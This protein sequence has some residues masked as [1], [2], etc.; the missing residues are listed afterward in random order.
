M[1]KNKWPEHASNKLQAA[2]NEWNNNPSTRV[3][4]Y[5]V[6]GWANKDEE[7][8]DQSQPRTFRQPEALLSFCDE[9]YKVHMAASGDRDF[10]DMLTI[11]ADLTAADDQADDSEECDE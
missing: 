7:R 8:E 9:D 4:I 6:W 2:V 5:I 11:T 3:Q 1:A 10:P